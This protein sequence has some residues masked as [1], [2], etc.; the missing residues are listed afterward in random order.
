MQ[1]YYM[2]WL[3]NV[4]YSTDWL[5]GQAGNDCIYQV[6]IIFEVASFSAENIINPADLFLGTYVHCLLHGIL[7]KVCVCLYMT[8]MIYGSIQKYER[9][10]GGLDGGG[11]YQA[12]PRRAMLPA[13]WTGYLIS[14]TFPQQWGRRTPACQVNSTDWAVTVRTKPFVLNLADFIL[15]VFLP[16]VLQ[17]WQNKQWK[18]HMWEL[19][20]GNHTTVATPAII[21]KSVVFIQP[22]QCKTFKCVCVCGWM[23]GGCNMTHSTL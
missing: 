5:R 23:G 17:T 10:V 9:F 21:Q 2:N 7:S 13:A 19:A 22:W 15:Y 16:S 18:L 4:E 14:F 12:S 6:F 8:Q 20:I 11:I 3:I 1:I